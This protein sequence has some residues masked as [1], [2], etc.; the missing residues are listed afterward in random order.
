[1][2][3]R[4][5]G[6]DDCLAVCPW[7]KF[8]QAGREAKL[9]MREAMRAPDLG[10]LARLDEAQFRA[11]FPKSGVKRTGRARFLRNVLIAIGNSGDAT[12][13][14]D[15]RHLLDDPSPLIRGAAVWALSQ[16]L[17]S[18]E[19]VAL[20]R[21]DADAGVMEEWVA[22]ASNEKVKSIQWKADQ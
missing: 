13:A 11:M 10:E 17:P 15:A 9:A 21:E 3:N 6:C 5:F 18:K 14:P 16:L 8:A 2:G 19:F 7:N 1:M 4:I 12:L 22:T 20:R